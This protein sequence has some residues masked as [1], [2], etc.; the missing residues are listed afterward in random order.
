MGLD[1]VSGTVAGLVRRCRM[2]A[3]SGSSRGGTG[4]LCFRHFRPRVDLVLLH[5]AP[6]L[7]SADVP[8]P[9]IH[10]C[11]RSYGPCVEE[12]ASSPWLRP[13]LVVRPSHV[14]GLGLFTSIDLAPGT[15]VWRLGGRVVSRSEFEALVRAARSDPDAPYVDAVTLDSSHDLVLPPGTLIHY[16]NHSCDPNAWWVDAVTVATRRRIRSGTEVTTDYAM[17][18]DHPDFR[19]ECSCRTPLCRGV[20]TGNDWQLPSLQREYAGH[21]IPWIEQRIGGQSPTHGDV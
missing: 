13:E 2:G 8:F 7:S 21:W 14:A 18:T 11:C 1:L 3:F 9:N 17:S 10:R 12:I 19:M 6:A 16:G 20:I 5:K 4:P 15:V